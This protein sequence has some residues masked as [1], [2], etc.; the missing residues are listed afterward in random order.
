[1]LIQAQGRS[2]LSGNS[3]NAVTNQTSL[4]G[5]LLGCVY[6]TLPSFLQ[7]SLPCPPA[8]PLCF[9]LISCPC[10]WQGLHEAEVPQGKLFQ[11]HVTPVL[12]KDLFFVDSEPLPCLERPVDDLAPLTEVPV[13]SSKPVLWLVQ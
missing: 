3:W 12:S 1:M 9:S 13:L 5:L 2:C 7:D 8:N 6:T 4:W 11:F 10:A